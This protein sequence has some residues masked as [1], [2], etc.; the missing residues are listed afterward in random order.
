MNE[1]DP[2]FNKIFGGEA[3]ALTSP[4]PLQVRDLDLTAESRFVRAFTVPQISWEP[5]INL[6]AP[7]IG[8][9]PPA[10]FNLYPDDGGPTRL[11]NDSVEPVPIAPIP[12]AEFLVRDFA[13]RREE[14]AF[15][16]ALFTLPFGLRAF[17]EFNR[18]NQFNPAL[19]AAKLA[20]NRPEYEGDI[21]GGLQLRADA[22]KH[23]A[24]SPIFKG[25]TLQLDNVRHPDGSPANAGT[26][27][28]SVAFIFNKEFFL[29]GN[30]G[31]KD[32]GVPLTRIDFSGYGASLFSRWQNPNA[33]IAATSQTFFDVFVG[34]TAHEVVQVRSLVYPWGIRVVRTITM[35]RTSSAHVFRFDTGWQAESAGVYDFS[36]NAYKA[37]GSDE[38]VHK[39]NPY[40]IHPGI[41]KGVFQVRNIRETNAVLPF[42]DVWNKKNGESYVDDNGVL[43][44]VDKNTPSNERNPDVELQPLYFDGDFEIEGVT[45]G[46]VGGHVP[47]KGMLGYVQL[48]PRGEPIPPKSFAKLLMSQL[49]SIGGPLDCG[50]NIGGSGQL[51]RLSRGDVNLSEDG[52]KN[53][54]FVAAGRGSVV[55]PKDGSW[56]VVQHNQGSGEVS[57]LEP[58][59][60]VPL[61]RRGKLLD[62]STQTTDATA[63]DLLRLANPIDLVR[64]PDASTRNY[65]LLQSTGTQKA[66]FRLPSFKQGVDQLL[67]APPDFADAYRIVNSKGIFPNV[68]DAL[69]LALGTFQTKILAEGYKLLDP[70]NPAKAFDQK[71]PEAPLYLINE[72]FLKIYVEYAKK[73]KA[74]TTTTAAGHLLYG[75]DSSAADVGK[76]WLSK[77]NDIGMVVDLGPLP[78]LMMIKGKFDAEKG[79]APGF[80][81]PE[82]EFSDALQ[83]VIDILQILMMLQGGDYKDAFQKGLE[84]AMSNSADAWSYAFHA[85]KE[86]PLVKFPPGELYNN[87]TNPLK[88]E[89]HMA[90][91]VYFNEALKVTERSDAA[92]PVGRRFPGV[93]R[94]ALGDVLQ[95]RRGQHLCHGLGGSADRGRYQDRAEAEYEVRFRRRDR[96]G[97]SGRGQCVSAL[98]GGSRDRSRHQAGHGLGLPALP[99]PRR[100]PRRDRDR[101]DPDRG[102][103]ERAAPP[104][105][106][107]APT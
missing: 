21:K 53:P 103:G 67:G 66:L 11:F 17:A 76:K 33:A 99:G 86:I 62:P 71:L 100:D 54:L 96:R 41:V 5:L 30:T 74:G 29:D 98:H 34:R 56:S 80:I 32:R 88:L 16:G 73:D 43:L 10:G 65:G 89:A 102:E 94:P 92:H 22:P 31:Y 104:R 101:D 2:V 106:R 95:P 81:E 55:L 57:P 82:L 60:T 70:G 1:R 24:E 48:A 26:L 68:Q 36:Y 25:S 28:H 84:V 69:P 38:L 50:I 19:D 64:N 59:A 75:F 51:M 6:T 85:R 37:P 87:P 7:K 35:F 4:Y 97:P 78:R 23:P 3:P 107:R 13:V 12:V 52:A 105:E 77:V 72:K 9:D 79:S 18:K 93:R 15:T 63:N 61:I 91:G 47:A 39:A 46:A 90:I 14:K 44:T 8:G 58:Q 20:F 45:S 27:G 83:P 42:K 49:G 40:E